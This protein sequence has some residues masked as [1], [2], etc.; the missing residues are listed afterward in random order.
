M[1]GIIVQRRSADN[2]GK[3]AYGNQTVLPEFMKFLL[4]RKLIPSL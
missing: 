4:E 3:M 1:N 2:I